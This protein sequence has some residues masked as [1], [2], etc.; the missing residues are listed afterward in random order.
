MRTG[1]V[2]D[3]EVDEG[4]PLG[5]SA[6]DLVDRALPG[7]EVEVGW[8]SRRRDL[9]VRLD[10]NACRIT[11]VQRPV[12]AEIGDVMPGVPL[13]R[14]GLQPEGHLADDADALLW[15]RREL[16]PEVV[17]RI[18]VEAASAVF[19]LRRVNEMRGAELRD[20]DLELRVL[21]HEDAR[22]AG[23]V[24]VDVAEDQVTQVCELEAVLLEPSFERRDAARGPAVEE[25]ES[26]VG[27][28]EVAPDDPLGAAM[29]EVD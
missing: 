24:E 11:R 18:A 12:G 8:R 25:R 19:Q 26:V 6:F 27:L 7:L 2:D 4:E 15:H 29:V 17:E 21:A 20:V 3:P 10:A 23:V 13:R 16:A 5:L 1:V 9:P 28:E 14:E 22:G